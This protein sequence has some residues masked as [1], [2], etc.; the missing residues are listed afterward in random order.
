MKLLTGGITKLKKIRKL[1]V[2]RFLVQIVFLILFPGL[3]TLTFAGLHDIYISLLNGKPNLLQ[4]LPQLT[5]VIVIIPL[6]I[7]LGRFFC[8]WFCVFGTF[9]DFMY[10]ISKKIFKRKFKINKRMDSILR[11]LKYFVLV[12]IIWFIW[13]MKNSFFA[14][15]SPWDAFAQI[16]DIKDALISYAPG[17]LILTLIGIGA[18]F[19]ER[20]FCR[21]LCPLGA[22]FS[23][24]SLLRG[25]KINKPNDK[26][27]NCRL[28]TM[29]CSMGIKL[30]RT[31]KVNSGECINCMKCVGVCPRKNIYPSIYGV[32]CNSTLASAVAITAFTGIYTIGANAA[33]AIEATPRPKIVASTAR[34]LSHNL[35]NKTSGIPNTALSNKPANAI[36]N[37]NSKGIKS[38]R[39]LTKKHKTK[40]YTI[41]KKTGVNIS[42]KKVESNISTKKTPTPAVNSPQHIYKD[43]TFTGTGTGFR[44]GMQVAV[45]IQNDKITSVQILSSNDTNRFSS[46][47]FSVIP[48]EIIQSQSTNVDVVSGATRSSNGVLMAVADALSKAKSN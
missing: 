40:T 17:F 37:K 10:M 9:N 43:G 36:N 5:E 46:Q 23:I 45:T 3:I 8:G 24:I 48:Q 42:T 20:F 44:P 35:N 26:C 6:T 14:S 29:Q 12:F 7:I 25:F 39:R 16:S 27:G 21:Y 22:V 15:A 47:A 18:M 11:F 28:C 1:Q 2:F 32:K 31:S 30:Y 4:L 19:I 33:S 41:R 38:P 13:T 34:S